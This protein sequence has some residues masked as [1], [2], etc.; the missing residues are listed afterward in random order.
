MSQDNLIDLVKTMSDD[1]YR[2]RK[3]ISRLAR[4][5]YRED[6][7]TL[8]H[9]S[10]R[11]EMWRLA[12]GTLSSEEI[13]KKIKVS[14]RAVQYFI[15]DAEKKGLI[16]FLKRGYPKRTDSFDEVPAEWKQYKKSDIHV[17]D[18]TAGGDSNE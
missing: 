11:Q 3:D 12:D 7:K 9:T 8:T 5:S 1:I 4:Q 14:V 15:Q 10:A 6:L 18:G 2:M 13:A 17:K 16:I